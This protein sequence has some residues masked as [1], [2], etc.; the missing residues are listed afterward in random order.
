M[1]ASPQSALVRLVCMLDGVVDDVRHMPVCHRV[2]GF[3]A[4][5]RQPRGPQDPEVLRHER[6]RETGG[7]DESGDAR[8]ALAD[9]PSG[10]CRPG[11]GAAAGRRRTHPS[12][13]PARFIHLSSTDGSGS[14]SAEPVSDSGQ[15]MQVAVRACSSIGRVRPRG[16][17]VPLARHA[18]VRADRPGDQRPGASRSQPSLRRTVAGR[19]TGLTLGTVGCRAC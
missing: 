8:L 16:R 1:R 7:L 18:G 2:N 6:L 9:A 10:R 15:G 5:A 13:R 11:G 12:A 3:T 17:L 14:A 4:D 19:S